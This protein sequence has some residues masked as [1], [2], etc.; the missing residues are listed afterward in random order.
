MG[1]ETKQETGSTHGTA[2]Q[3]AADAAG[4]TEPGREADA[5]QQADAKKTYDGVYIAQMRADFEKERQAAVEAAVE[6]AL[7]KEK[8]SAEDKAR[9]EADQRQKDIE[10][11]EKEIALRELKADAKG[12]LAKEKL[13]DSFVDMVVGADAETTQNNINTLR[14][15]IDA[16]V[17]LQVEARLKG[18]APRTGSG[19]NSSGTSD[20]EAQMNKIM[21]L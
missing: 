19:D 12:M 1:E 21:G 4:G 20:M 14:A 7:K 18:K 13:S 15:A 5:A 11:R 3:G 8:M 16:E 10:Q 2:A 9:Y 6:E 17:Q